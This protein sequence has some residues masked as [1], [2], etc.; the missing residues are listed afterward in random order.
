MNDPQG[1]TLRGQ[2]QNLENLGK[3]KG[4]YTLLKGF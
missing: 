3:T 2:Y 4:N 1:L